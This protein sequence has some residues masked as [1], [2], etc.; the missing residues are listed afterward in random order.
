M[1]DDVRARVAA[2]HVE[3]RGGELGRLLTRR[4]RQLQPRRLL[5][6]QHLQDG[7]RVLLCGPPG[8]SRG[9]SRRP[10]PPRE[11][12]EGLTPAESRMG[13]PPRVCVCV[14]VL[15]RACDHPL[16]R[17]RSLWPHLR[18]WPGTPW[19]ARREEARCPAWDHPSR[20]RWA[21]H[22]HAG[23]E[24][25]YERRRTIHR[26]PTTSLCRRA[27]AHRAMAVATPHTARAQ[28]ATAPRACLL[29]GQKSGA[30]ARDVQDVCFGF[31]L[32]VVAHPLPY[33]PPR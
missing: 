16:Q 6:C 23:A 27:C 17:A 5:Q 33:T 18:W 4:R 3:L 32:G 1:L 9:Q 24:G 19:G 8:A 15:R 25:M 7:F 21:P 22:L 11:V 28:Y 13:L 12:V 14:C 10:R 30:W 29:T 2:A 20:A 31:L 26:R